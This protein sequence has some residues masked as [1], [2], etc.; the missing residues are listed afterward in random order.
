MTGL[1]V[2]R[3]FHV[4]H[5][6]RQHA[7]GLIKNQFRSRQSATQMCQLAS[8]RD[9]LSCPLHRHPVLLLDMPDAVNL[10]AQISDT[11]SGA[12][13]N[14][15]SMARSIRPGPLLI[16]AVPDSCSLTAVLAASGYRKPSKVAESR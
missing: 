13:S 1:L 16:A 12:A 2:P 5:D 7:V 6:V 3:C 4:R 15:A 9:Q 14:T 11:V 10:A 8:R